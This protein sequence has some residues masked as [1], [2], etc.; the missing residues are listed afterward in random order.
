M[1]ELLLIF[2][3]APIPGL[4]KTRL[5]PPLTPEEATRVH[6]AALR[7]TVALARRAVGSGSIELWVAGDAGALPMV[8]ALCPGLRVEAQVG[9]DLG[10]RL[11]RAFNAAFAREHERVLIIGS[12]HPTLPPDRLREGF[13][14]LAAEPLVLG[15]SEDGGYYAVGL[16]RRAWPRARGLFEGVPWS[17][18]GVFA[19]TLGRATALR[20]DVRLLDPWYDLDDG[21]DL[22]RVLR[23][24]DRG[25]E[26]AKLFAGGRPS[27]RARPD[28]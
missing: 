20:L 18:P 6:A 19:A 25:S 15:P 3:K 17:S 16:H 26:I 10:D 12:D 23:D 2:T 22:E 24:A 13:A 9:S 5:V 8:A 28:G 1:S 4:V 27:A 7:D 14:A 21:E 11:A